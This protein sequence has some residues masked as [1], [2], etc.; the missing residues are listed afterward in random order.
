MVNQDFDEA[1]FTNE[2]CRKSDCGLLLDLHNIYV[3]SR[4]HGTDPYTF[5]RQLDLTSVLEPCTS[6]AAWSFRKSI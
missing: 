5:L 4:N 6:Q 2:L 1:S 3:N